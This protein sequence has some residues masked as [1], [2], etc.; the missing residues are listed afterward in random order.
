MVFEVLITNATPAPRYQWFLNGVRISGATNSVLR[1]S[2]AQCAVGTYSVQAR[3][4]ADSVLLTNAVL[5]A[6]ACEAHQQNGILRLRLPSGWTQPA[7]LESSFN[8]ADWR[9][10]QVVY[11]VPSCT[12]D[13]P[14]TNGPAQFLRL[15]P[16]PAP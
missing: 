3:N 11:P 15:R 7:L 12:V 6:L 2:S 10:Q 5:V 9:T 4:F 16:C 1:L 8:L 13:L 14:L